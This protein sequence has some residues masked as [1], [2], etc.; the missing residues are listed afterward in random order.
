MPYKRPIPRAIPTAIYALAP[1]FSIWLAIAIH[2]SAVTEPTEISIPPVIITIVCPTAI[3][4]R[5]ALEI[6]R[7]RNIW[8]FAKPLSL[9]IIIPEIY[10]ARNSSIVI[11]RRKVLE[12]IFLFSVA[13]VFDLK[14]PISIFIFLLP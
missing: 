6:S 8:G 13:A 7:S 10:I 1:W 11:I 2:T 4:R 9:K 12:L 3:T 5:P 14:I